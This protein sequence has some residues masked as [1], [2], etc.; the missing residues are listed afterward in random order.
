MANLIFLLSAR[1]SKELTI[2]S[3]VGVVRNDVN[4]PEKELARTTVIRHQTAA[5]IRMFNFGEE[6]ELPVGRKRFDQV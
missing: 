5:T 2:G 6:I 3:N 1:S 4:C